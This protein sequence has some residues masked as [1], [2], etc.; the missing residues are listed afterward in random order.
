MLGNNIVCR[1]CFG[2]ALM[3]VLTAYT[4]YAAP[5][6]SVV[7][8][9]PHSGKLVRVM[10]AGASAHKSQEPASI[11]EAKSD[12]GISATV[13]QV[14]AEHELPA[15][16]IRS[17]IQAESNYNPFAISPKGALG[18]MQLIPE[19]ARRFGVSDA[20]DP[21]ENIQGGAKY[22]KYLLDLYHG[23]Y[24]LALAAYN[25]GEGAVAKHGG[26]PPYTETRKYVENVQKQLAS[27]PKNP[28]AKLSAHDTGQK[29]SGGAEAAA[30]E[31]NQIREIMEPD[32]SVRYVSR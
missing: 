6:T 3:P 10:R 32:G 7:Q 14:A 1:I 21:V 25:A 22:L 28:T 19:T 20:F 30:P 2:L 17:V 12:P 4:N 5:L 8:A 26:V 27:A 29:P 24:R 16:L 13:E 31:F 18:M 11:G 15:E 9:D 23:D